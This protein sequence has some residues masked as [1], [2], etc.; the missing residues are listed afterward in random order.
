MKTGC[1]ILFKKNKYGLSI[2]E[3]ILTFLIL[4]VLMTAVYALLAKGFYSIRFGSN[5]MDSSQTCLTFMNRLYRE[6]IV[7]NYNFVTL[8]GTIYDPVIAFPSPYDPNGQVTTTFSGTPTWQKYIFYYKDGNKIWLKIIPMGLSAGLPVS[9][10]KLE[11]FAFPDG[12]APPGVIHNNIGDYIA[13]NG[14]GIEG[15]MAAA[16]YVDYLLFTRDDS[17]KSINVK[18]EIISPKDKEQGLQP[19]KKQILIIPADNLKK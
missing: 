3:C 4:S 16:Y 8:A 19:S 9:N 18:M 6:L 17:N 2:L 1:D 7:S 14:N 12:V 13:L 15:P 5:K 11:E 10:F